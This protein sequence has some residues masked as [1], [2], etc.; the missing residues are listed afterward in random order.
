MASLPNYCGQA[1]APFKLFTIHSIHRELLM[2]IISADIENSITVHYLSM[3]IINLMIIA[4]AFILKQSLVLMFETISL[5]LHDHLQ[6]RLWHT[7]TG[8]RCCRT[9]LLT[10]A[11]SSHD[12]CVWVIC[13]YARQKLVKTKSTKTNMLDKLWLK[14]KMPES[15]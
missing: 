10:F 12:H 6:W 1:H 8:L 4:T 15:S 9:L 3:D 14:R 7:F 2:V 13:G 5:Q 11:A